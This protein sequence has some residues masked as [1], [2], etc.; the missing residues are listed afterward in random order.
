[1]SEASD[2]NVSKLLGRIVLVFF[3]VLVGG[4]LAAVYFF[5]R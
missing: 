3:V 1:M 4:A 5:N 2:A